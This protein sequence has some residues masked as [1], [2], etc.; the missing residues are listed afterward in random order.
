MW[1]HLNSLTCPP[2]LDVRVIGLKH[3]INWSSM[4]CVLYF[5]LQAEFPLQKTERYVLLA[6]HRFTCP[7]FTALFGYLF[8]NLS[9]H[10]N[11]TECS[12]YFHVSWTQ[13]LPW[14]NYKVTLNSVE[15]IKTADWT[16]SEND[17]FL[18]SLNVLWGLKKLQCIIFY[19]AL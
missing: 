13:H 11:Q 12:W 4:I 9:C 1:F 14:R 16:R 18:L 5:W 15:E 10:Y 19:E 17:I 2:C 7:V 8:W 3:F 6:C